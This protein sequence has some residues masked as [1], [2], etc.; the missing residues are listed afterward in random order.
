MGIII[1]LVIWFIIWQLVG[2]AGAHQKP[3]YLIVSIMLS[4][5]ICVVRPAISRKLKPP[6]KEDL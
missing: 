5:Y 6:G 3:G 4:F 1:P 2:Y